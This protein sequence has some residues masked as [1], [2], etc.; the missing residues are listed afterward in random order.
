M[1]QLLQM[2]GAVMVLAGFALAQAG[3]ID[4]TSRGYL[5]LNPSAPRCSPS[6]RT[7]AASGA[8]CCSRVRG[9]WCRRGASLADVRRSPPERADARPS[10]AIMAG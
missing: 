1:G 3:R 4:A 8:S 6:R 5:L 7:S 10:S 9:R 2:A